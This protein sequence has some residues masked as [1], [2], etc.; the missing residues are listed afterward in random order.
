M[1]QTTPPSLTHPALS[2][3]PHCGM[4]ITTVHQDPEDVPEPGDIF[5]C[6]QCGEFFTITAE[7]TALTLD[8]RRIARLPWRERHMIRGI[9]EAR[10]KRRHQQKYFH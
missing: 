5:T 10:E 1:S 6:D 4:T 2:H 8:Q 9:R 7:N 3:C